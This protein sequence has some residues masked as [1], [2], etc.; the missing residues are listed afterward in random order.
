MFVG[1][2]IWVCMLVGV[3]R[4]VVCFGGVCMWVVCVCE[5]ACRAYVCGVCILGFMLVVVCMS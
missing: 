3:C 4:F 1:V 5:L 2:C